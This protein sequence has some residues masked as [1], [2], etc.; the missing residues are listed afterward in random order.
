MQ[1]KTKFSPRIFFPTVRKFFFWTEFCLRLNLSQT[2]FCLR[3]H[4]AV[5]FHMQSFNICG[6]SHQCNEQDK[7]LKKCYLIILQENGLYNVNFY[8][9]AKEK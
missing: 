2:D 3:L 7:F 1:S 9:F 8:S 6:V 5:V 4:T